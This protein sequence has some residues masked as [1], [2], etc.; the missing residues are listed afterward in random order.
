MNQKM[1]SWGKK[2]NQYGLV[3]MEK[4]L[5]E[6]NADEVL[7]K[8]LA[9]GICGTDIGIYKGHR[10]IDE[11]LTP[12][13]EFCGEIV[14]VGSNVSK[15]KKGDF[16]IPSI[17]VKCG[18]CQACLDG[19]E[20]QCENLR[21]IGIHIDGSFAEYV[22]VPQ[23]ALHKPCKNISLDDAASVEPVAVAVSAVKKI[24]GGLF[25][26]DVVVN[27][28]GAIGLYITQIS[29]MAGARSVVV[30]G[31]SSE[32]RLALARS[33]GAKTIK[34]SKE[35]KDSRLKELLP[36]RKADVVF[37]ASGVASTTNDFIEYLKPHGE[38]VLVGI[39]KDTGEIN[40]LEMVRSESIIKGSFCYTLSE[41]ESAIRLVEENKIN[42]K[43]IV[44]RFKL[45]QLP[46]AF[47][48]VIT[49][50]AIKAILT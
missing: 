41:F 36:N 25:G 1:L 10:K 20:S 5:P 47:D 13:H 35:D 26:K 7:V 3:Q 27:G 11:N 43:G 48:S 6:P 39:Y 22:A 8:V 17:V 29:I 28:P 49:K 40:L 50:K 31:A 21:E 16:V 4:P 14:D 34:T 45:E 32:D 44:T 23:I 2:N 9:T 24:D 30:L 12:G 42:F 37:E 15:Y 19:Y 33:Y 46:E 18:L 38:L